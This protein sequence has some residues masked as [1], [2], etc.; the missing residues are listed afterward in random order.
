[1]T[2]FKVSSKSR[3]GAVAGAIAGTIRTG[4]RVEAH[5]IGAGAV[6][7]AIK[8]AVLARLFLAEDGIDVICLPEFIE[9]EI[10]GLERTAI[11]IIVEP[12]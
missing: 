2:I 11:K 7:R 3:P 9:V 12:R 6:Y 10:E 8:A 1:M 4:K 5:A